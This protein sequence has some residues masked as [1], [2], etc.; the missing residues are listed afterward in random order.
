MYLYLLLNLPGIKLKYRLHQ[1]LKTIRNP[2]QHLLCK[3]WISS[4]SSRR[5]WI[6]GTS[7]IEP[8]IKTVMDKKSPATSTARVKISVSGNAPKTS[9]KPGQWDLARVKKSRVINQMDGIILNCFWELTI[10][11]MRIHPAFTHCLT[12]SATGLNHGKTRGEIPPDNYGISNVR[13]AH[14]DGLNML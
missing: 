14:S 7:G 8:C 13:Y 3:W 11:G 4:H 12:G 1:K 2:F 5:H 9:T 10:A 6:P